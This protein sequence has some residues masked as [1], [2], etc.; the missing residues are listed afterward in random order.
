MKNLLI[1]IGNS[2]IKTAVGNDDK[3]TGVK[4]LGYAKNNFEL[5]INKI[6]NYKSD[7]DAVGVS[8]LNKKYYAIINKLL[9]KKFNVKPLFVQYNSK[10]PIKLDYERT[11]GNDRICSASAA[12]MKYPYKKN[13]L[14]IDFG[15]ATTY[16]LIS[17]KIFKGGIIT[18]GILTSL[19]SLNNKANLPKTGIRGINKL[20]SNK[21][22]ENIISGVIH[23]SLFT[24]EG[25]IAS[26]KKKY[27]NLFVISTGGLV[28]F[29]YEK[30]GL[31]N[32]KEKNLVLEGI[33]YIVN[34][35]CKNH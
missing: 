2:N 1:D 9:F 24:A 23:Q 16:N 21:T 15:T 4:R 30:S 18:P 19:Q 27:R 12:V 6:L 31:I 5:H 32:K 10:L 11:L 14:V 3:I 28:E 35:N 7:F 22:K 13:I 34:L 26:L 20:I 29:V 33:N 8:C 17:N 25:V